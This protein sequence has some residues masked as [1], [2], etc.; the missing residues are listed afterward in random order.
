M[1]LVY[2]F[3][4]FCEIYV[5]EDNSSPKQD[6]A[7]R[8]PIC[9]E[10]RAVQTPRANWRRMLVDLFWTCAIQRSG[11]CT[12]PLD[13][14]WTT[15]SRSRIRFLRGKSVILVIGKGVARRSM[16]FQRFTLSATKSFL[17]L[18][19]DSLLNVRQPGNEFPS[20]AY[21]TTSSLFASE[22]LNSLLCGSRRA[23]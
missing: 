15:S 13:L 14:R 11:C 12:P 9:G 22:G 23:K 16:F 5:R 20:H 6:A 10:C 8:N 2:R 1:Y 3:D 19:S 7:S 17:R 4:K 18:N 21:V